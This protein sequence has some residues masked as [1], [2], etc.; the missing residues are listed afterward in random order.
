MQAVPETGRIIEAGGSVPGIVRQIPG[1]VS[2]NVAESLYKMMSACTALHNPPLPLLVSCVG[3]DASGDTL[4]AHWKSFGMS[5]DFIFR[6]SSVGSAT[7]SIIFDTSG[8]V[9]ASIADVA[10][11]ENS[12]TP[13]VLSRIEPCM[14]GAPIVMIDGDL[15]SESIEVSIF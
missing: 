5:T 11:V 10:A 13:A 15:C 1:G 8:D 12:L 4:V 14:K 6:S 9:A 7:I 2:H 3:N